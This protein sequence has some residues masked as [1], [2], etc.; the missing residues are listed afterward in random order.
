MKLSVSN[1][2]KKK[3]RTWECWLSQATES[4]KWKNLFLAF[5]KDYLFD[6]CTF[7]SEASIWYSFWW[8]GHWH[9]CKQIWPAD[10]DYFWLCPMLMWYSLWLIAWLT[11]WNPA[12]MS[13]KKFTTYLLGCRLI[14][15]LLVCFFFCVCV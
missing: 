8:V 13:N 12:S 14:N 10:S 15:L 2:Q 7:L 11:T 1:S 9:L 5:F 6:L 4:K 3:K